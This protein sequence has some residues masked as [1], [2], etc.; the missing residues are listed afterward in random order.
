ML[1]LLNNIKVKAF[2][3]DEKIFSTFD[4]REIKI[5]KIP[6]EQGEF[7]NLPHFNQ[8]KQDLNVSKDTKGLLRCEGRPI[9]SR[10]VHL[11][12]WY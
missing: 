1:R 10:S 6:M 8:F 4:I 7:I 5:F 12:K 3:I 9:P 11:K 2:L